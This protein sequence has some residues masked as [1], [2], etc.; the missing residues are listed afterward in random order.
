METG[1]TIIFPSFNSGNFLSRCLKAVELELK[2]LGRPFEIIVVDSS[3]IKPDLP[4]TTNLQL[5][6]SRVQLFASE[7]RNMGANIAKYPLLIFLDSDVEVIP[8]AIKKIVDGIEAGVDVMAGVYEINNNNTS[9]FSTFQDI[10]LMFRYKN[11]PLGKIF[12]S[13]GH[14]A[15]KKNI[16][17]E[18]GGFA[19]SL[20]SYEDVEFALKLQKKLLK[21]QVCFESRGYHLKNFNLISMFRDYYLKTRNMVFY[22]LKNL[23][24]LRR[25]ETFLTKSMRGSYGLVFCYT[26]LFFFIVFSVD[27]FMLSSSLSALCF[28]FVTDIFLLAPFLSFVWQLTRRPLWIVGALIFFKLTTVPII[29]GAFHG[30][31]NYLMNNDVFINKRKPDIQ[32]TNI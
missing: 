29:C 17:L 14:F 4:Q 22:R 30:M 31:Y 25:A 23:N 13:S 32:V 15:I 19:E 2:N 7:A 26:P 5:V 8:G 20:R 10:F 28:L 24:D 12:F 6:H 21:A 1:L 16:F 9:C 18:V 27:Q 11:I 3:E